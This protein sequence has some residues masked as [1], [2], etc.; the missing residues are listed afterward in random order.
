MTSEQDDRGYIDFEAVAAQWQKAITP[1]AYSPLTAVELRAQLTT[2]AEQATKLLL[3]ESYQSSDGRHLG[4]TLAELHILHGEMLSRSI[5]ILSSAWH[6]HLPPQRLE[7]RL[8]ALLADLGGGFFN[9]SVSIVLKEQEMIREAQLRTLE[10]LHSNLQRQRDQLEEANELL[11]RHILEREQMS[12]ELRASEERFRVLFEHSPVSFWLLDGS[13]ALQQIRKLRSQ[14]I[15]DLEGYLE[16]NPQ[17]LIDISR[18][19][20]DLAVNK[21]ALEVSLATVGASF[22]HGDPLKASS[23][24]WSMIN[25][26][27]MAMADGRTHLSDALDMN[28]DDG[29]S[30]RTLYYWSVPE[31][32]RETYARM[33]LSMVDIS[34]Q[35]AAEEKLQLAAE[36]L[37]TLHDVHTGILAAE[38]SKAIA[39]VTLEHITSLLDLRAATVNLF[40][41]QLRESVVLSAYNS[42]SQPGDHFAVVE[43]E[44]I[45]HL[46]QNGPLV[47]NDIRE[48]SWPGVEQIQAYGGRS[49]L[50]IPLLTREELIGVLNLVSAEANAFG[51]EEIEISHQI[52]NSLAIA[53]YN[54]QLFEE[55]QRARTE[56]ETMREVA[57]SLSTT[58][59]QETLLKMLL[60]QL[61]LVLPFD[62]AAIFLLEDGR[63]QVAATYGSA[64]RKQAYTSEWLDPPP[65]NLQE[66][67][68][69][70]RP[71]IISDTTAYPGWVWVAGRESVRCWLGVP[72]VQQGTLMGILTLDKEEA[73][74]YDESSA[75]LAQAFASQAAI[76]LENARLYEQVQ[77]NAAN[78]RGHVAQRTRQLKSLYDI[79]AIAGRHLDLHILLD[80]ALKRTLQEFDCA[81]G[82]VLLLDDS[83][84]RLLLL[85]ERHLLARQLAFLQDIAAETLL[86]PQ[87]RANNQP[88]VIADL[89]QL[90]HE[91]E[92]LLTA[93]TT[94]FA[95]APLRAKGQISGLLILLGDTPHNFGAEE[96]KQLTSIADQFGV[97]IENAILRKESEQLA[98]L[99]ERERLARDLHDS[100]TQ[101]LYS[102]TL[103][104]AAA[105]Q[106]IGAGNLQQ[107]QHYLDEVD[108]TADQ[109]H[110]EMRLLLHELSDQELLGEGLAQ[111]IHRRLRVVEGRSG[112]MVSLNSPEQIDLPNGIKQELYKIAGEA[113]TNTLKH[114]Q[115]ASVQVDILVEPG[116]IRLVISDDGR[117]FDLVAARFGTGM[118]LASMQQRAHA[119]GGEYVIHSVPN[120]GTRISVVVP[121]HS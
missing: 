51:A 43:P 87:I 41:D 15:T 60:A 20:K 108:R 96:I 36:R 79:T 93:V 91:L 111:A 80:E 82:A 116:Q 104:S 66:L 72:L 9:G 70:K 120:G 26:I 50:L 13:A 19:F 10:H 28:T 58:L 33:I 48:V 39:D 68:E 7:Q 57:A 110:R 55:E 92:P 34:P 40:E 84:T 25:A 16:E 59:D 12:E 81:A 2:I 22:R 4:H 107:A 45:E 14:G 94:C 89:N 27:I 86:L 85:A 83:K 44:K 61:A 98:V 103:F 95:A 46:R 102:L 31:T 47:I 67:I 99:Q 53:L 115:A 63:L 32:D 75:R 37:Q 118:G 3:A 54:A 29:S 100:A 121:Y 24:S 65:Q 64:P 71:M 119:L 112:M 105:R 109:T 78:L 90:P 49:L 69:A 1:L 73:Y 77:S 5:S 8:P 56:A 62:G 30:L 76:A 23:S 17:T 6:T 101:S 97:A 113:L 52:G 11:Q 42:A 35:K 117:G 106:Q 114:A 88:Q 74:A 21:Q 38:S 18:S